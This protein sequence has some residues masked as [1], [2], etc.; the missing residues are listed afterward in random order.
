MIERYYLPPGNNNGMNGMAKM[1]YDSPTDA[2]T[3]AVAAGT[4]SAAQITA[5]TAL[6]G[7]CYMKPAAGTVLGSSTDE[8][9][10]WVAAADGADLDPVNAD[11]NMLLWRLVDTTWTVQPGMETVA[12]AQYA[13]VKL[14]PFRVY[15]NKS[16]AAGVY[17]SLLVGQYPRMARYYLA[18]NVTVGGE[19]RV[20]SLTLSKCRADGYTEAYCNDVINSQSPFFFLEAF[21]YAL[22]TGLLLGAWRASFAPG[23]HRSILTFCPVNLM[24]HACAILNKCFDSIFVIGSKMLQLAMSH[25]SRGAQPPLHHTLHASN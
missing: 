19:Q 11:K 8:G 18:A 12:T 15:S 7:C 5:N 22:S 2:F 20:L 3:A 6:K 1:C 21:F 16:N 24:Y 4:A 10:S 14:P 17:E 13:A 9:G 23:L 25:H